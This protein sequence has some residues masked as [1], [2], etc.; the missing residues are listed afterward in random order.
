MGGVYNSFSLSLY[1]YSR[2]NPVIYYDID[3]NDYIFYQREFPGPTKFKKLSVDSYKGKSDVDGNGVND[4]CVLFLQNISKQMAT[5]TENG[6]EKNFYQNVYNTDN[7]S[8][9]NIPVT[10]D[11]KKGQDVVLKDEKGNL[12]VNPDIKPGTLI[13]TFDGNGKYPNKPHGN[14]AAVF[15]K[16][17]SM[18]EGKN[19][20]NGILV[21]DSWSDKSG[22][23]DYRFLPINRGTTSNNAS[24]FSVV[25]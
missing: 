5:I 3:G 25:E 13:A 11:W 16:P 20:I 4:P 21:F 7:K 8:W 10:G 19:T 2:L 1:H 18:K 17:Y 15:I 9:T 6:K 23:G 22:G 12:S 24:K 14:H